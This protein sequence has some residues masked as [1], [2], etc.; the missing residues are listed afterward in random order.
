MMKIKQHSLV[1]LLA[2]SASMAPIAAAM[3]DSGPAVMTMY[4]FREGLPQSN[5]ALRVD[6]QLLSETNQYGA[7]KARIEPGKHKYELLRRGEVIHTIE[8]E[9]VEG[10]RFQ[11]I[12]AQPSAEFSPSSDLESSQGATQRADVEVAEGDLTVLKGRVVSIENNAPVPGVKVFLSGVPNALRTD[13]DGLYVTEVPAGIYSIS[14]V[15]PD[16]STQILKK[17]DIA[18]GKDNV[19]ST[20]M[21]PSGLNLG[22]VV[23]NSPSLTGGLLALADEK[24][25]SSSVKDVL[26][27]EQMSNAGDSD[28]ASALSRVT[29][30]TLIDG[31]FVYVRGLGER[32]SSVTLNGASVP[33]PD[34]TRKVI[35]LDLFPT[36]ALSSVVV[37]KTYSPDMP[38][39]FSGGVVQLRTLSQLPEEPSNSFSVSGGINTNTT[40]VEGN[41]Y[42]GGATDFLGIDDGTRE[43]PDE[44]EDAVKGDDAG[45]VLSEA[46]AESLSQ[47]YNVDPLALPPDFGMKYKVSDVFQPL[48]AD[49]GWGYNVALNYSNGWSHRITDETTY[50][51]IEGF[52]REENV[53]TSTETENEINLG[54]MANVLLELG[55]NTLLESNTFITRK[56]T[57]TV[58]LDEGFLSENEINVQDT[59]LEWVENQLINQQFRGEH[60]FPSANDLLFEWQTSFAQ[61]S[62]YEPDTR[63]YRYSEDAQGDFGL[64]SS[65]V[66]SIVYEDLVDD[67]IDVSGDFT[68]PIYD[69][70][71]MQAKLKSGFSIVEKDRDSELIRLALISDGTLTDDELEEDPEDILNDDNI[72]GDDTGDQGYTIADN[73]QPSDN[74]VAEQLL[75]GTYLLGE[76]DIN[77]RHSLMAGARVES[78]QQKVTTFQ[79]TQQD[80]AQVGELDETNVMPA[81]SYTWKFADDMQFRVAYSETLN[82]PDFKELSTA[83]Y[84]DPETRDLIIGNP[85][86]EQ[87]EITNFDLRWEWYL[88]RYETISAA[89]FTKDF[90]N[91][92]EKTKIPGGGDTDV[93]S[94]DNVDKAVNT[95]VEIESRV[96]LSRLLGER[97]NSYYFESNLSLISSEVTITD[98]NAN[99]TST[100]RPLQG[101]SPWIV[102]LTLGYDDLVA[103]RK[104]ALVFNAFGER[105]S[106]VGTDGFPDA[107][108]QTAPSLNFVYKQEVFEGD[109]DRLDF[110]LK[111]NNL[112]DPEY[113]ILRGGEV[114]SSYTKGISASASVKYSWK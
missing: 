75:T 103:R 12:V 48:D 16:Y 21:T 6:G 40:F 36:S 91:P 97:F 30:L 26:S 90:T 112:L 87:A 72:G 95:G 61:A 7:L 43:L 27:A 13:A 29:G 50:S 23:V 76:L 94:F 69:F 42:E 68:L 70:F 100:G 93:F 71:G 53:T 62:R 86:L 25:N 63:F 28:A 73:T 15:H 60:L 104:M 109:E 17:V 31:K 81:M 58:T 47:I 35:P 98:S 83:P 67:T 37:Q 41:T 8:H 106:D 79:L 57:N 92:I 54:G 44:V 4:V 89:F 38:G 9:S 24:R 66:H 39:D 77:P 51:G 99:L 110:S 107:Y 74:Y 113:V 10:E 102:N 59:T 85:N 2:V 96:W 84:I 14:F 34:P 111:L 45:G 65:N 1:F 55:G 101:Q 46:E 56:T 80:I 105:I 114:E 11:V 88:T 19:F 33:S 18:A 49:Y 32:Y 64:T 52:L 82:R 108:E 3:A 22:E 5:I 20:E 78:N